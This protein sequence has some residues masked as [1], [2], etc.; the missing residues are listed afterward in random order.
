MGEFA[1]KKMKIIICFLMILSFL[2]AGMVTVYATDAPTDFL[3]IK[4]YAR[5]LWCINTRQIRDDF[6]TF[7]Q[8]NVNGEFE[9]DCFYKTEAKGEHKWRSYHYEFHLDDGSSVSLNV[10]HS[11][12]QEFDPTVAELPQNIN[13]VRD[14][15]ASEDCTKVRVGDV[16]YRFVLQS[17]TGKYQLRAI[18]MFI[19]GTRYYWSLRDSQYPA[20][21]LIE[22]LLHADTAE[23]AHDEFAAHVENNRRGGFAVGRQ[24]LC[25]SIP[26]L[27]VGGVIVLCVLRNNKCSK[28]KK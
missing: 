11:S 23:A 15:A 5:Y 16:T 14:F 10:S 27:V 19:D 6:V 9:F 18:E 28:S 24:M 4:S 22:R 13:D 7:D 12:Q 26:I 21:S 3:E 17:T 2:F 8:I 25:W 20:D 1:M